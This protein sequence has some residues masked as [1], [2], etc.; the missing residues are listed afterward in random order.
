MFALPS[1]HNNPFKN[2]SSFV[3]HTISL[4]FH[5]IPLLIS[6]RITLWTADRLRTLL[7]VMKMNSR[8]S[9][10][11]GSLII[12]PP[13]SRGKFW[14][15]TH[16]LPIWLKK[17]DQYVNTK[18]LLNIANIINHSLCSLAWILPSKLFQVYGTRVI[19]VCSVPWAVDFCPPET[20]PDCLW[21]VTN[22]PHN[23]L[24]VN[25]KGKL[26]Q[27]LGQVTFT[28]IWKNK[29]IIWK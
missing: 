18:R 15:I 22:S 7:L 21:L 6:L 2:G 26:F 4:Y 24:D 3:S 5:D 12:W 9:S 27:T 10:H 16:Y 28:V 17:N 8:R 23:L 13:R 1:Q 29:Y 19:W 20:L 14:W 25:K 11:N